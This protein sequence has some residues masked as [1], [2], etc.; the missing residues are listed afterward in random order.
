MEGLAEKLTATQ[1]QLRELRE[2][3]ENASK[4][5]HRTWHIAFHGQA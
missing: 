1:F 2:L 3:S 5:V 4:S